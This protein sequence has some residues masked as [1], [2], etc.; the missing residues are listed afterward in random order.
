MTMWLP[1]RGAEQGTGCR[2]FTAMEIA[3]LILELLNKG[4]AD[5]LLQSGHLNII[6]KPADFSELCLTSLK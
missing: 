2:F 5:T 6:W 1:D 4:L 3:R